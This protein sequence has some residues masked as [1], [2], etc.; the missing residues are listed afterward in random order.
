MLG[1]FRILGPILRFECYSLHC[2]TTLLRPKSGAR[3]SKRKQICRLTVPVCRIVIVPRRR[4]RAG[5]RAK[6]MQCHLPSKRVVHHRDWAGERN[7]E[8]RVMRSIR[9][10]TN[11][12]VRQLISRAR[13]FGIRRDRRD[14][15][16]VVRHLR[17]LPRPWAIGQSEERRKGPSTNDV[18][19]RG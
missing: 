11:R 9:P 3:E 7:R 12:R 6:P 16:D 8:S 5:R 17:R 15:G 18:W 10:H 14:G 4:D 2:S 1:I 13:H 19:G